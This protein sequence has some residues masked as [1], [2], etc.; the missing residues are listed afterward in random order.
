MDGFARALRE[1]QAL[2]EAERAAVGAPLRYSD[3]ETGVFEVMRANEALAVGRSMGGLAQW[4][5]V[6]GA[7][8]TQRMRPQIQH[9][10]G[11]EAGRAMATI[12]DNRGAY[13]IVKKDT[14]RP[15]DSYSIRPRKEL[16]TSDR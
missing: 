14:L 8:P 15:T 4:A 2:T 9:H 5:L 11:Y 10:V 1:L 3:R 13:H 12:V 16:G 7:E 6:R